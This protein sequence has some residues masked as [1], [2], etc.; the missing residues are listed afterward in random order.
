MFQNIS[1]QKNG[2]LLR[3]AYIQISILYDIQIVF[4]HFKLQKGALQGINIHFGIIQV[5]QA[6]WKV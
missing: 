5:L 6:L 3:I 1:G 2:P 4:I